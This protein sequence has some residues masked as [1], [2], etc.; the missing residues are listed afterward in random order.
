MKF[1]T[2]KWHYMPEIE[3]KKLMNKMKLSAVLCLLTIFCASAS[4]SYS[5][6]VKITLNLS[7][8][9]V[10]EALDEIK[11]QS[12]FSFWYRNEEIDLNKTVSMLANK[13]NIE[14]VLTQLLSEQNLS[15][16]IDEKHIIIY[17]KTGQTLASQE[18]QQERRITGTVTDVNGEPIIGANVVMKG[19]TNGTVT[20]VDGKFSLAVGDNT[21]LI[22]SFIGYNTQELAIGNRTNLQITLAESLLGLDEVVVI[23]YGTV[24]KKDLTGSVTQ[25]SSNNILKSNSPTLSTA[26]QGQIPADIG[27]VWKPGSNQSI[28][29]RGISSITGSNDPLWVVDGIPM[30]STSV[31]LNPNDVESIDIL[32]DASA[33][34]IYGAR[35]SNGVIIVTTK[36]AVAGESKIKAS[37]SG[38]AGF[39]KVSGRPNFMSV[40]EFVAYKRAALGSAGS[41]NSDAAIFDAVELNSWNNR[42]FTDWFDEVWGGTAFAT[43]HN[44]TLN[45]SGKK[46]ATMLSLGYLDQG[47]LIETAGYRRYNINFNNTFEFSER[48]KFTTSILGTYSKNDEYSGYVFHVYQIS[49][50]GTPRDEEGQLKLQPSPNEAL[51][52]NPLM[53]VQ[54]NKNTTDLY[55]FIG[56]AAMEWRIWDELRYKFSA[57]MD[58]TTANNGIYQG[59]Q[60]RDRNGG[61]HA[62]SYENTTRMSTI[63]DNILSYNK[64]IND[65]H[66]LGIMTAFNVENYQSKS[67]YLQ[68]TDMY[69]DGLY[70][71]LESASSVL[72]K[73]TKLSEWGIMSYMGRFNYSLLD[74]YLMTF[75]YRYDGSSRLSEKN[76][77][78]GF[79]SMSVAWRLS[80]ESFLSTQKDR[81]LDNL[82]LRLS[83]G[84]TGN[85]NVNPYETLGLL[86]KTFYSWNENA[87]IGTIPT[88]IPNPDLRWEKTEEY[89]IGLDFGLFRSR[90]SGSI[91]W[92]N[93]TTKDLI[94]S[95]NLPATSGYTSITQ[96]IGSTRNRGIELMLNGDVI[97]NKDIKWNV[98]ITF[99]KNKNEILDLF[100]DKK[101]DVGSSYFIG[102]PIRAYYRLDF[103]GVW[104]EN[105]AAE[106]AAYGAK[107]GY[108]KYRDIYNKEG[109]APSINLNDDRYII[110]REPSWVG[111]LNTSLNYK[112]FD[113]YVSLYTRQG[114]RANSGTHALSD[115]DPVRY[116]GFSA[117]HWTP[118]NK[119]NSDPAPA[120][121]GTYTEIANSDYYIK[122]VS[123]VRLS[124]IS[125][126]Y[127]VP[128]K[129]IRK[130]QMEN[131]KVFINI[132]NPYVWT[133]FDGQD[134]QVGTDRASYPAVT[135]YQLGLNLNF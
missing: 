98:G 115:D 51:I 107:P 105:E 124:N 26:L 44:F 78:A 62:A 64:E 16:T 96:N 127:T 111:G 131:A 76:K 94:L 31:S 90:L 82:K 41:D 112:N 66:R 5:Q 55:G 10:R 97:R 25:I 128:L 68:G 129:F 133:P 43:N 2:N 61:T 125:L 8:V 104:Q 70:Y 7:N 34:A 28:E 116:I 74:R 106:A 110:S 48:L 40:D 56:S 88:G 85:T 50:L 135:S 103:I 38:W 101:D 67:V 42:T 118:E 81:F 14:T 126:G 22:V 71:N 119:S 84:N 35:G 3:L 46:T 75:T 83:W 19:T 49:P 24:K 72:G 132:N 79:P 12:E 33:S 108:P 92:Y 91:D 95:R 9:T 123:F 109:E 86:S 58:F 102:Q 63:I 32:K 1:K 45:A 117:N 77:W 39:D 65:I 87:A 11:K 20:D 59:S 69:F 89:N 4:V 121:K 47:S 113:L 21:M 120:I 23:G 134:P 99:L 60:T 30:Q 17:R 93:R 100:G 54:N 122:D 52:T 36:R 6:E 15:Y 29:I 13:Q 37:Y 130:F 53:E 114:V 27:N 18:R 73:N 57:G 80:E